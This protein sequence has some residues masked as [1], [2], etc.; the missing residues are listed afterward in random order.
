MVR[1]AQ[2][3]EI[4]LASTAPAARVPD[5]CLRQAPAECKDIN[6]TGMLR[7]LGLTGNTINL[8]EKVN[9]HFKL[10]ITH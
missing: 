1:K 9:S 5:A 10:L 7:V 6:F 8:E 2:V 3:L 4:R